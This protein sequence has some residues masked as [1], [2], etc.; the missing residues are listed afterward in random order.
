IGAYIVV[1]DQQTKR[2]ISAFV[3]SSFSRSVSLAIGNYIVRVESGNKVFE[4]TIA[5]TG[6][7]EKLIFD[8]QLD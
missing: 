2:T 1:M 3:M 8:A 4:K 5:I 6:D 7:S